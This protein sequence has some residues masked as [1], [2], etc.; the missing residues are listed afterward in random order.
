[1][2]RFENEHGD[3]IET[4]VPSVI[5]DYRHREGFTELDDSRKSSAKKPAKK[6]DSSSES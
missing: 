5:N 3:V 4:E 6:S 1:M 2:A